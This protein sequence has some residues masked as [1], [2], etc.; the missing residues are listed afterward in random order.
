M[1]GHVKKDWP[2]PCFYGLAHHKY[3]A[4][5]VSVQQDWVQVQASVF[6]SKY[7]YSYYVLKPKYMSLYL[8]TSTCHCT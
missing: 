1:V 5:P 4:L 3:L 6:R 2:D 7:K 8:S